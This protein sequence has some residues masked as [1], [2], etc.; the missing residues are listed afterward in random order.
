M[1]WKIK[2]YYQI[3]HCSVR[4]CFD[5]KCKRF[6]KWK[7]FEPHNFII[8]SSMRPNV[9]WGR[10]YRECCGSAYIL[11]GWIRIRIEVGKNEPKKRNLKKC[12]VLNCWMLS[13]GGLRLGRPTWRPNNKYNAIFY[14]NDYIFKTKN[15]KIFGH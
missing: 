2:N 7:I 14:E 15:C 4:T 5:L 8:W 1:H 10:P 11:V 6:P 9:Q 13:S 3:V 12:T